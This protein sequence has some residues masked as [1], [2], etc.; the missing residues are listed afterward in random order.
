MILHTQPTKKWNE[1]DFLLLEAYQILESERCGQCGLPRYICHNDSNEIQFSLAEDTCHAKAKIDERNRADSKRTNFE[2]PAGTVLVPEP[3]STEG[4][5]L[6]DYRQPY[7][8]AEAA[9]R[10]EIAASRAAVS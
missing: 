7:Y 6:I 1:Y 10:A 8:E 5:E 4:K 9:R 3:R 2:P